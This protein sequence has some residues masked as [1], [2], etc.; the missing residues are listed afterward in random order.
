MN[1][2]FVLKDEYLC[3]R[4]IKKELTLGTFGVGTWKNRDV[5]KTFEFSVT[6]DSSPEWERHDYKFIVNPHLDLSNRPGRPFWPVALPEKKRA[7]PARLSTV[8]GRAGTAQKERVVLGQGCQ[9]ACHAGRSV[10]PAYR[11]G[12]TCLPTVPARHVSLPCWPTVSAYPLY[13]FSFFI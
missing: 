10:V 7:G 4:L 3:P 2:V 6:S 1:I 5:K 13:Q 12:P 8:A 11:A 9:P